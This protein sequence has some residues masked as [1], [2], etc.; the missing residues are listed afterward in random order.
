MKE[1]DKKGDVEIHEQP[2][3]QIF[4]IVDESAKVSVIQTG[5]KCEELIEK[6]TSSVSK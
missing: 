6:Q 3:P 4:I 2:R 5:R 1:Q